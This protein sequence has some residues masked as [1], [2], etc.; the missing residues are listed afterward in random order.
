MVQIKE[1]WWKDTFDQ[2][3]LDTYCDIVTPSR[4]KEE[5][6]FLIALFQKYHVRSVLDTACG[7]GRHS[8]I[9]AKHGFSVTGVDQSR[10]FIEKAK[11]IPTTGD[12]HFIKDDLRVFNPDRKF[13]AV[14]NIFTSFGYF[15]DAEEN[16]KVLENIGR[17]VERTGILVLDLPNPNLVKK[18]CGKEGKKSIQALSN[19]ITLT[20]KEYIDK[21]ALVIKRDWNDQSYTAYI[22]LFNLK[23]IET[24]LRKSG[25]EII[26][27]FG[28]F[29]GTP[30]EE[31][32]SPRYII[33]SNHSL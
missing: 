25:F 14:I 1:N 26:E 30:L 31:E 2:K 10:Y 12:V 24:M 29:G 6:D 20:T 32:K 5:A 13:D 22:R 4:T 15:I 9:L 33:V 17:A 28:S 19:G 18:R 3:Y 8:I 23:E 21:D 16:Q 11:S 27:T 7:Y